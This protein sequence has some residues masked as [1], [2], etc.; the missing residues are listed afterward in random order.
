[1]MHEGDRKMTINAKEV[2]YIKLGRGGCWEDISLERQ[3]LHF[4]HGKITHEMALAR[5]REQIKQCRIQQ[6]RSAG[7][8]ADDAREICDFYNLGANCLW[9]T[10][11]KDHLWWTF[12][13]PE[14]TWLGGLGDGHGERVRKCIGGWCNTDANGIPI[15]MDTL[16]TKLTKLASYR[17]TLCAVDAEEYLMRRINGVI[18]PIVLE[19][20]KARDALLEVITRAIMTLH[21]ADFETMVDVIFARSGWH[22]ASAIGGKQKLVDMVLEQPTTGERGAVQV[23]SAAGQKRLNEFIDLADEAGKFDRLFFSFI[24]RSCG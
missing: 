5:D 4:G 7:A 22:R 13:E 2:R 1:M 23:K 18:E 14:V 11:A 24:A 16:S 21:W 6:G 12:A 20:N 3:E 8:A 17:C 10:L 9:I 15:R 19:S